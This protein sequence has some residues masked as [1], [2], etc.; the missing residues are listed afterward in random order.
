VGG[1]NASQAHWNIAKIGAIQP[2]V[3]IFIESSA[4]EPHQMNIKASVV[5]IEMALICQ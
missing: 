5:E 4:N 2:I 3:D 1:Y